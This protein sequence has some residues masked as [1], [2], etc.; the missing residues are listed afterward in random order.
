[1]QFLLNKKENEA[2]EYVFNPQLLFYK[3]SD[4]K[5]WNGKLHWSQCI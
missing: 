3:I 2:E 4:K 1:M 5:I